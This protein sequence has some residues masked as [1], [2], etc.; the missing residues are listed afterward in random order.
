MLCSEI[1]FKARSAEKASSVRDIKADHLGKLVVMKGIVTRCT[2]VKP[3]IHVATYTC[4]ECGS[5]SYQTVCFHA[6]PGFSHFC[7]VSMP[8]VVFFSDKCTYLHAIIP[9]P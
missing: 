4:D 2:E 8:R 7:L 5:D 6:A 3:L 1:Y 9:L